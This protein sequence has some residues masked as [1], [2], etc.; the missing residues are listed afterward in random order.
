MPA[1]TSFAAVPE[2]GCPDGQMRHPELLRPGVQQ[3]VGL[4]GAEAAFWVV[5]LGDDQPPAGDRDRRRPASL[6]VDRL[7]R[8]QVITRACMSSAASRSA[9]ARPSCRVTPAPISVTTSGWIERRTF[10]PPI[11]KVSAASYTRVRGRGWRQTDPGRAAMSPTSAVV[12]V[13]SLGY[14]HVDTGRPHHGQILQGHLGWPVGADLGRRNASRTADTR[15]RDGRHPDEVVGRVKK[16]A[17]V[18]AKGT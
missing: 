14:R 16:A 6:G 11:G 3:R 13:P 10:E 12:L 8:I 7:D 5:V 1:A 17:N 9:A 15:P 2:P 4:R 18:E